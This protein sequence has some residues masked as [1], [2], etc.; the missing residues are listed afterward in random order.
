[1]HMCNL[2]SIPWA[3]AHICTGIWSIL[4]ARRT[5]QGASEWEGNCLDRNARCETAGGALDQ[6]EAS[7][8]GF[9]GT[10]RDADETRRANGSMTHVK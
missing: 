5:V 4:Q 10:E 7:R 2:Y 9:R 6:R 1:M 8:S 3:L